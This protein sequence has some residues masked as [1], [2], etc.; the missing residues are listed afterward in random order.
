MRWNPGTATRLGRTRSVIRSL[1]ASLSPED[2]LSSQ[3]KQVD[4]EKGMLEV[5]SVPIRAGVLPLRR[6]ENSGPA[7]DAIVSLSLF[8]YYRHTSGET[9]INFA[10][11]EQNGPFNNRNSGELT[12]YPFVQINAA[13]MRV[14][15]AV[16]PASGLV[17]RLLVLQAL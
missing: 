3:S 5:R 9:F 4:R 16:A 15:G 11:P 2:R 12:A 6:R 14:R 8:L 10:G 17:S 1:Y 13:K 7:Y